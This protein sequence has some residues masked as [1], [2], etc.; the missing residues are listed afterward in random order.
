MNNSILD[1]YSTE[2]LE[3]IVK[4]STSI[5]EALKKAGYIYTGGTNRDLFKRICEERGIDYSHFTSQK[6]G[7]II[8]TE[9]NVFCKDSTA[10]QTTL[11]SW[12]LKGNYTKYEC[13]I[14]GISTWN[15]KELTLRLDHI[16][17]HNKDN[18]LE[19][20]RWVCPNCDSQLDTFCRGHQGLS[21]KVKE[22][23]CPNCGKPITR[24]A[25]LCV[26]C[27]RK[28]QQ[29]VERPSREELKQMIREI[30]F[31][32]IAD[33][34]GVSDKAI[35]KWCVAM[36]LPSRKKEI[37]GISDEDWKNI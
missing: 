36:D 32:K 6:K 18:R 23:L 16:N 8:R 22:N 14:C 26:D 17:G 9:E 30:P 5:N 1:S 10:A 2:Q 25:K 3:D 19:N 34:Y 13:A 12:Y 31:V 28:A 15:G 4:N 21:K 7:A 33:K 20:L 35:V 27:A 11:R 29:K 37:N 24:G